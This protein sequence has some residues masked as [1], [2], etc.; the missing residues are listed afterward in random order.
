MSNRRRIRKQ[1]GK[2]GRRQGK[3]TAPSGPERIELSMSELEAILERVKSSLSPEEYD[4][5]HDALKTLLFLTQ[6]LEKNRVSV[7]RL[8]QL[9]FGAT[10]EKTRKV[11]QKTLEKAGAAP[12]TEQEETPKQPASPEKAKGHGRNGADAY[13]GADKVKI[14]HKKL[15]PG[16]SCPECKKGIVYET[17]EPGRLVRIRGQAPLGATVY[18]LQKLRCNLCGKIFTAPT[19]PVVEAKKY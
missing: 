18:E 5:L 3:S 7:Q 4:K 13:T 16:D 1:R 14:S 15:Q 8:K 6:E 10:T 19:P 17:A 12:E 9:L 11:L 2:S